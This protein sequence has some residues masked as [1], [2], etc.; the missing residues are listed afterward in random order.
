MNVQR[1]QRLASVLREELNVVL[2]RGVKDPRLAGV[3]V[4]R[5][6][7]SADCRN[8]R[9]L[10]TCLGDQSGA[11]DARQAFERARGFLRRHLGRHLHIRQ[12][13]ELTFVYDSVLHEATEVRMLIDR[14]VAADDEVRRARGSMDDEPTDDESLDGE[15]QPSQE[16]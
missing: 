14:T 10:F 1:S 6:E 7:V 11:K 2:Q 12:V 15:D 4:T 8:A 9:V 5:I 3:S 13:P 16:D